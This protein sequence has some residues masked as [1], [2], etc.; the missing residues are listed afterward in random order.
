MEE[1]EKSYF[2]G[3]KFLIYGDEHFVIDKFSGFKRVYNNVQLVKYS[4][5]K[6]TYYLEIYF[7]G[8]TC[9]LYESENIPLF[10]EKSKGKIFG[11]FKD[12]TKEA[13]FISEKNYINK[14]EKSGYKSGKCEGIIDDFQRWFAEQTGTE[15]A[16]NALKEK[17]EKAFTLIDE[18]RN[19]NE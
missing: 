2:N 10:D 18:G 13:K 19:K 7:S 9:K 14:F 17:I 12:Y 4:Y 5:F 8:N 11:I 1:K 15:K 3:M 6:V 16:L